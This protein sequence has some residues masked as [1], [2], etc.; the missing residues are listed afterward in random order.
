[1][2][3]C[4]CVSVCVSVSVYKL[5]DDFCRLKLTFDN[6]VVNNSK[7]IFMRKCS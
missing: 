7:D 3:V 6:N 5:I 2:C 1:M 4:V